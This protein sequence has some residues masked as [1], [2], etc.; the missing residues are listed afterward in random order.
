VRAL[1]TGGG[2][3]LGGAIVRQLLARG[4]AVRSFSRQ[5]YEDLTA[6][7]V[8][9][10][11]GDLADAA[12]VVDAVA[13]CDVVFHVA[14]KAGIW[15][16]ADEYFRANVLGT[17]NVLDAC[18]GHRIRRLVF[19][20]SPS[21]VGSGHDIKGDN[22]SLPFARDYAAHYPR[23]K[24]IAEAEVLAANGADL[25]TVALRPHLI[26]GPGDPHLIPR[27]VAR[28]KAGRLRQVGDGTNTVDVTYI[29][30]AAAAHLLAADR[31][32][33]GSPIAGRA[34]FVSNGEPIPLW[35]FIH[36][37]LE[38]A[39]APPVTRRIPARLAYAAGAIFE[40]VYGLFRMRLEPPMTR[41]LAQQLSTSHWFDIS[42]ARHDLGYEPAVSTEVGL[43]RL[44]AWLNGPGAR[45]SAIVPRP[46]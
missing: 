32:V 29:E 10:Q 14:A 11:L 15:G 46:A 17:R 36:Q 45:K 43:R 35:P 42:A 23:T 34:Y 21:V 2:G 22:E 24:A 5:R 19:T 39:G 8:E 9:Q 38:L 28:A 33:P 37:V 20:S 40:A 13:G 25:A 27:M 26:W 12:T 18:R 31:L 16:P 4:D 41:F 6:L 7:G 30:N 44:A 3:F 1:V